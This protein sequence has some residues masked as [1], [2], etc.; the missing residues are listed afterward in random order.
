MIL[1]GYRIEDTDDSRDS[2]GFSGRQSGVESPE[3]K[4]IKNGIFNNVG[5]FF[6]GEIERAHIQQR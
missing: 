3:E 1:I 5:S 6:E 2:K 4:K